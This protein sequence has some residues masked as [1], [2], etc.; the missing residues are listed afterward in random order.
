[1]R[2]VHEIFYAMVNC[3]ERWFCGSIHISAQL[4]LKNFYESHGFVTLG[5]EYLEDGDTTYCNGIN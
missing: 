4:H 3:K 2:M 5:E 1:M